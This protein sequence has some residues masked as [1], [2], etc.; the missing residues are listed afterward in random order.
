[1][2]REN[3]VITELVGA[4][5]ANDPAGRKKEFI[6][7][8]SACFIL[9]QRG[10]IRFRY[11]GGEVVAEVGRPVFL[12]RGLSYINECL[13][14]AESY[15][16][17]FQTLNQSM[18]PMQLA[19]LAGD[20]AEK[21]YE[22]ICAASLSPSLQS[23]LLIFES[24]YALARR[25]L[26]VG[27]SAGDLHPIVREAMVFMQQHAA[28]AQLTVADMA[29]HCH[30]SE[31]WLRKLLEKELHTTPHRQLIA[32]RMKKASLLI[33]DKRPLKEVAAAVGYSDVFQFSRAYKRHFGHAP[34]KMK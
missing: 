6:D 8:R 23:N 10:K 5:I 17:N 7:R 12:P 2:L 11:P 24:L 34:S 21:Y 33:E 27:E 14:A 3:F 19:P 13:E 32:I 16:F 28:N 22:A 4:F 31:I 9:T 1:M 25:L 20:L 30:I 15:V 29:R 18:A 26:D